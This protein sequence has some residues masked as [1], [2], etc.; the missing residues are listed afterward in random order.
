MAAKKHPTTKGSQQTRAPAAGLARRRDAGAPPP[1]PPAEAGK[2]AAR[3]AEAAP[4]KA[5]KAVAQGAN[6]ARR[7][8]PA[9]TAASSAAGRPRGP[10]K[11]ARRRPRSPANAAS[12]RTTSGWG[13]RPFTDDRLISSA[14]AGHDELRSRARAAHRDQSRARRRGDVDAKWEDAYAVG[15]EAPGGDNP[16]PDQDRVDDIGKALGVEL[17]ATTRNCRAATKSPSAT[18]IAG[19]ST[20]PRRTTGRTNEEK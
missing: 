1:S 13:N 10:V 18:S 5:R 3:T 8:S 9:G 12:C 15:D 16:T 6:P 11:P 17:P 20:R 2:R 14:R 19:S 4:I 7:P